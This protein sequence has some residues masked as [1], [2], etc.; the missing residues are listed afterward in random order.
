MEKLISGEI[1]TE[2]INIESF[3]FDLSI[4]DS[5]LLLSLRNCL[6]DNSIELTQTSG[7]NFGYRRGNE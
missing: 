6:T 4:F 3:N 7:D 2:L 5:I 1:E